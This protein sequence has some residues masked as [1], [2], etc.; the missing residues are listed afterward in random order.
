MMITSVLI[1]INIIRVIASPSGH[2]A[3]LLL[4]CLLV[5]SIGR[6][7]VCSFACLLARLLAC[8]FAHLL[9]CLI[10]RLFA[11][12]FPFALLSFFLACSVELDIRSLEAA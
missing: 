4:A 5:C 12:T 11:C 6:V 8:S 3:D 10:A 2:P 1:L 7:L 9:D